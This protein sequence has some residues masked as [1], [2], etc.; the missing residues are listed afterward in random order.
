SLF[1]DFFIGSCT[2]FVNGQWS[3]LIQLVLFT[4]TLPVG[5][6]GNLIVLVYYT[7]FGKSL[8]TSDVFLLNLT[9]CDSAWILTLPLII[10]FKYQQP[11][12]SR[13]FCQIKNLSFNFNI[14]GSILFLTLI[15]FDRYVGTVHPI[16]S[17]RWWNVDKAK[18]CSVCAWIWLIFSIAPDFFANFSILSSD[19][20][21]VCLNHINGPLVSNKTITTVRTAVYF[22]IPFCVMM[23]FYTK[24]IGVLR[25]LPKGSRTKGVR[26]AGRKPQQLIVAA[27]LVFAVSF[28]PYHILVIAQVFKRTPDLINPTNTNLLYSSY[29]LCEAVCTLSSC[30]DPVLYCLTSEQVKRKLLDL[31]TNRYRRMCCRTSRRVGVE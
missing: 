24:T 23:A 12:D 29:E 17:L 3:C 7:C 28:V 16:S 4:L 27:I 25:R 1:P 20:I 9:V 11:Q 19:N 10:Y 30:L 26:Q 18:I 15:S 8:S 22:L 6:L 5:I 2:D 13:A 14:Y 21:T 31:K